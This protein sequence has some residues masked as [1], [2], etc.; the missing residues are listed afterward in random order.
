MSKEQVSIS[1]LMHSLDSSELQEAEQVRAT[2]NQQLSSDKG[3]A[4]LSAVVDYYLESSSSQA[5]LLLSSI[6]ETH[7]KALLEKLNESLNRPLTRL[8]ALTLLGHLIRKQ[9]PWVHHISRSAL[10]PSLLRCLKTDSDVVVLITAVLVLVTLLPMIPQAGKQHIYD[11]F[12]VFGRLA[13][14]S[15][16]NPAQS[17]GVHLV[18]LHAGVYS[19]FHRLYGMFPCNFISYLRLHYSMKEN[20]DTFQEVVKPMLEHVRVHPELVTGTQDQELEP[21]RWRC[22]EVHDI[23]IE[24]SRVS[25]DPLESSCEEDIYTSLREPTSTSLCSSPPLRPTQLSSPLPAL[26]LT[27]SPLITESV[28][29][30]FS[31]S[32]LEKGNQ[33]PPSLIFDTCVQADDVTWSPSLYCGLSTPPLES[34]ASGSTH[35]LSRSTS[36]SGV[37]SPSLASVPPTPPSEGNQ[38]GRLAPDNNNQV[39][40]QPITELRRSCSVFQAVGEQER[41]S[42]DDVINK[43]SEDL[44]SRSSALSPLPSPSVPS[45]HILLTSTPSFEQPPSGSP[46][47]SSNSMCFTPSNTSS[48]R[49]EKGD[50]A[51]V[52]SAP[53]EPLF[54]LALPQ[55]ALLFIRK[56]TQELMEKMTGQEEKEA[57]EVEG[58]D[59]ELT[60]TSPDPSPLEVLNQL[61]TRGCEAHE[62]L[63]RRL[64]SSN[65]SVD[66]SHFGGSAVGDELQSVKSQLLLIHGQL[67]YERFK[68]QQHAMRNRR[69]LRRVINTTALEEQSVA[70]KGQLSVQD[71]EIRSLKSSL[72]E[73]QRRYTQLQQDTQEHTNQLHTH[74]QQLQLQQQKFQRDNQRLQSELQECHSTLK[75]QEAELQRANNTA[76]NAEHRLTK[77]SLKLSN[78]EQLEQQVILLNQQLV[79]LRETNRALTEQLKGGEGKHWTE[80]SMLQCSVGKEHQRLKEGE[81]QQRQKLEAASYRISDLESQLTK[82]DQLILDQKKLLEDTKGQSRAE[83]SACESRCV[84]LKRI[85]QGLQTEMLQLYSQV[86]LDTRSQPRDVVGRSDSSAMAVPVTRDELKPRPSSSSVSIINGAVESLSTSPLQLHS[87]SSSPLSLSPIDSPLT[88]GSFLEKQTRRQFRPTNHSSDEENEDEPLEKME[89]EEERENEEEEE[90][91]EDNNVEDQLGSPPLGQEA[92][93]DFLLLKSPQVAPPPGQAATPSRPLYKPPGRLSGHAPPTD[94]TLAVR[95]RRQELSIMDYNETL[96]EF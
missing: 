75:V 60:Q 82:K 17:P 67:E 29:S 77:L 70:M 3:G 34:S 35:P 51:V 63:S 10:L 15:Y 16:R 53:Y 5:I 25:L 87:C 96:P 83:L 74:V 27:S 52:T 23:V 30:A 62:C 12:D 48:F 49:S 6:R 31:L 24:C 94:L 13:S 38:D 11:F 81:V 58:E 45:E 80:A 9:P 76:N 84:A 57:T 66:R 90:D 61:I 91:E 73:E 71:E 37:K 47:S 36:I 68:R 89:E 41:T 55:A 2:V 54:D 14:W 93:E 8:V 4:V 65:K 22:Y 33:T 56:R 39:K 78:V 88:V 95:Q 42:Y 69:L 86:H 19:L 18:H 46:P 79:V 26:D 44:R 64:S 92:E 7:H 28:T 32:S 85:T 72:Q 21:S 59:R 40:P 50:V 43:S 1:D 20:L